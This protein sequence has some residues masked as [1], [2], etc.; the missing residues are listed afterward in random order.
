MATPADPFPAIYNELRRLAAVRLAAEHAGHTLDAT[1]LVHEAYLRVGGDAAD[2]SRFMAAAAEAMRRI[3]ID[4]ARR[5]RA[6]KRGGAARRFSLSEADRIAVPEAD[7]VLDVDDA[8]GRLAAEDPG[9]AEVARLRLFAGLTVDEA[10]AAAGV[11]RATAYRDWA[12][13]RAWLTD[14]LAGGVTT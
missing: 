2:R 7:V 1:A 8:L 3:L 5:K 9:A 12:Y 4:H 6:G 11:S 14:A 13:A 10:A